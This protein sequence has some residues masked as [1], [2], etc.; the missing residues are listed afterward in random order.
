M[1]KKPKTVLWTVLTVL[2]AILTI[3]GIVGNIVAG[4]YATTINVA[5]NTDTFRIKNQTDDMRFSSDFASKDALADYDKRMG[6]AVEAEGATLLKNDNNALPLAE[7][8]KVSLFARGSVDLVYGGTGSGAVDTSSAPTLKD[9][10]TDYGI[11]V[12]GTL[13]DWYAG[14]NYTR[15]TPP[16]SPTT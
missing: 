5:L 16:A 12:N 2:T 10:L 3:V 15:Q 13:W 7:G 9:A 8:A 6:I 1:Q 14:N 11:E 4:M